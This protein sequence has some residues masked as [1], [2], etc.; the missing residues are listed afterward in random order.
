MCVPWHQWYTMTTSSSRGSALQGENW[1][2]EILGKKAF[3][4]VQLL[5]LTHFSVLD[6]DLRWTEAIHKHCTTRFSGVIPK[7][8][9]HLT[10]AVP[11]LHKT[12]VGQKSHGWC[13]FQ[14]TTKHYSSRPETALRFWGLQFSYRDNYL[15]IWEAHQAKLLHPELCNHRAGTHWAPCASL[16]REHPSTP[17]LTKQVSKVVRRAT[18]RAVVPLLP[19]VVFLGCQLLLRAVGF[20]LGPTPC[21]FSVDGN[22]EFRPHVGIL[23]IFWNVWRKA[24]VLPFARFRAAAEKCKELLPLLAL[25]EE[26][27]LASSASVYTSVGRE[28]EQTDSACL[29]LWSVFL[30]QSL[31]GLCRKIGPSFAFD[32]PSSARKR[33]IIKIQAA[34]QE[35]RCTCLLLKRA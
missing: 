19:W 16:H 2:L 12:R 9:W 14:P 17:V 8:Y 23:C 30:D 28:K 33:K 11:K 24:R 5:S 31:P 21:E 6:C 35:P 27:H 34:Q 10:H 4:K 7:G 13:H 32:L 1:Y 29:Q 15:W 18:G 22:S 26:Q 20:S 3:R 25:A